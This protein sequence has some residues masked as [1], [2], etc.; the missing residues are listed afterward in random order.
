MKKKM[1]LPNKTMEDA[2]E[3]LPESPKIQETVTD[4]VPEVD[5]K[6]QAK[7]DNLAK[8]RAAKAEKKALQDAEKKK[9]E[10]ALKKQL[11]AQEREKK[12]IEKEQRQFEKAN[13]K[14]MAK[15][16]RAELDQA[17]RLRDINEARQLEQNAIV[18]RRVAAELGKIERFK[19]RQAAKV[20]QSYI[21]DSDSDDEVA[22][23]KNPEPVPTPEPAPQVAPAARQVPQRPQPGWS[24]DPYMQSLMA[25][26]R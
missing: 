9:Q 23:P 26:L 13:M 2:T 19:L 7:L 20:I 25:R 12:R 4:P 15:E 18:E 11:K 17:R 3:I 8:A 16:T 6:R 1:C 22:L 14:Y 10:A 24:Q 21:P 5:K